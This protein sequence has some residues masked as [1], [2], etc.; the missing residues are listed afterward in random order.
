MKNCLEI[1]EILKKV[2]GD[3]VVGFFE[4]NLTT[5]IQEVRVFTPVYVKQTKS[6]DFVN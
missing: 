2:I 3:G 4:R 6:Q 1:E 5:S